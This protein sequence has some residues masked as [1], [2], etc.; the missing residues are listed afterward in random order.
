MRVLSF[1]TGVALV[2]VLMAR[3]AA[4]EGHAGTVTMEHVFSTL[5][6]GVGQTIDLALGFARH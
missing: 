2:S 5:Q 6:A 3:A 1:L 4:L